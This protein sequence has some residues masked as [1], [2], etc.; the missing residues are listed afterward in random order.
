MHLL[1]ALE[2]FFPTHRAGTEVYVLNL[3]RYFKARNWKVS[4][5][6]SSTIDMADY[7][8]EDVP[9]YTFKVAQKATVEELNGIIPPCGIDI[10]KRRIEELQPDIVHFHSFGRAINGYHLQVVKSLGIKTAFTPHLGGFFC[11]KGDLLLNGKGNCDGRVN[12]FR[13]LSCMLRSRNF[14][15]YVSFAASALVTTVTGI[16]ASKLF[17][18]APLF[19]VRHRINEFDR[20]RNN[21]DLIFAIAPWIKKAFELNGVS[22]IKL[23]P[24]G[25]TPL[26]FETTHYKIENNQESLNFAFIGRMH[27][28]KGFHLLQKAWDAINN[29]KH[30]LFVFTSE[31]KDEPDYYSQYYNWAK[32]TDNV[33][34]N[35]GLSQY[36]LAKLMNTIDILVLPSISNEVAPLVIQECAI[37]KI[38]TIGSDYVALK[39]MIVHEHN[40]LLFKNGNWHDLQAQLERVMKDSSLLAMLKSNV[41]YPVS[42][43]D[44][45]AIIEKEYHGVKGVSRS[46]K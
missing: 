16:N 26:F 33:V 45:S 18:P 13:C 28:S 46:K 22:N 37:F 34:W 2:S 17:L 24:Q 32:N 42:M 39:D 31:S 21:A 44:V 11:I 38:P 30:K 36:Q 29:Y 19:Q 3:C 7:E 10:F 43:N 27:P 12:S 1:F 6:I 23:I 41:K 20:V 5:L 15:K 4:V 14:N 25:I 40:G 9:V 35:E 8:Y